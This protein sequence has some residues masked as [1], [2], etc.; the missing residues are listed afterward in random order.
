[1]DVSP[2]HDITLIIRGETVGLGPLRSDLLTTYQRWMNDLNV[3]RTLGA[4]DRPMT[5]E[6]ER[7]WL[8]GALASPEPNFTIYALPDLRPIGNTG[9]WGMDELNRTSFF[10]IMI[11]ERDA[12]GHGYGAETTR[13]MLNYAFDV[14][15]LQNVMLTVHAT[16]TRGIRAYERA[17]FRRAGVRRNAIQV[18]RQRIDEIMMDAIPGD[19]EPSH[20]DRVMHP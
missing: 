10:G 13:L 17:G 9:L 3:T 19:F 1:M 6:R 12:W 18:G 2:A 14:L 5:T 11:G 8:D 4:P 7:A 15:G 16:N 20:L